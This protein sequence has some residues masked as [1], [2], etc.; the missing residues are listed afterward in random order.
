MEKR[1]LENLLNI[2]TS[3]GSDYADI[4]VENTKTR[5][6]KLLDGRIDNVMVEMI[7]GV[8]LRMCLEHNTYYSA[9]NNCDYSEMESIA[10]KI[11]NNLNKDRI[12]NEVKLNDLIDNSNKDLGKC[13]TDIEKKKY[14]L[15]IDSLARSKSSKICQVHAQISETEQDVII[16]TSLNKYIKDKRFLKRLIVVVYATDGEKKT[17]SIFSKGTNGDYSFLDNINLEEEINKLCETAI[18]KL[19]APYAPSGV[20]PVIIGNDSGVLIHEACGHALEATSVADGDSVLADSLGKK[21]A[22][23]CVTIIDDGTLPNFW[24]TLDYDDEGESTKRNILI[25][26]GIVTGFLVD[27]KNA[28]RMNHQV[29]GSGRRES[30]KYAPTSRMNNTYLDNGK[31]NIE[32]MINSIEFGL[33]AKKMGGGEVHPN[34]G[35][36]N[37][38]VDEAYIIRDGKIAEM[39]VGASLI[40]NIKDVL[41]SIEMVSNDLNFAV[42]LCGSE[43]GWAPVTDGQPT[44]KLSNILVGGKND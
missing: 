6:I 12:I 40:G 9:L 3:T 34:T 19:T 29:T 33:Y 4:F 15:N 25:D 1:E 18:L 17:Q 30:Y 39:V 41:K 13:L 27:K 26:K 21:V 36:F 11:K 8:G 32:D 22:N 7:D 20:M 28:K 10:N 5:T 42:G 35:N 44:I 43:S 24:G 37:F 14:L 23:P 2:M 31:D 16:A 38:G